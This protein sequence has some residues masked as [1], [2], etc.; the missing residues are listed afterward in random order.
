MFRGRRWILLELCA[1][2]G[3]LLYGARMAQCVTR[4]FDAFPQHVRSACPEGVDR[5]E[6]YGQRARGRSRQ[7]LS[8][9]AVGA[10]SAR[11]L[12]KIGWEA[13]AGDGQRRIADVPNG[14]R[15]WAVCTALVLRSIVENQPRRKIAMQ[16]QNTLVAGIGDEQGSVV[17]D[18]DSAR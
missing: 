15:P 8:G 6:V 5:L 3:D 12:R 7:S 11:I 13:D 4:E 9:L 14:N 18:R 16:L 10:L 17:V 1:L 2:D